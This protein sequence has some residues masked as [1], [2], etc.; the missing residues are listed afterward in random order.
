MSFKCITIT[1]LEEY[2]FIFLLI[3]FRT[4]MEESDLK[5]HSVTVYK[6]IFKVRC[7]ANE[8]ISCSIFR[9]ERMMENH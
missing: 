2:Q 7:I 4:T 8:F 9:Y 6:N 3:S 1:I 5:W